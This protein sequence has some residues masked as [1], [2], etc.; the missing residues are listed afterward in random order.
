MSRGVKSLREERGA[1]GGRSRRKE[2]EERGR[3]KRKEQERAAWGKKQERG[4]S[5]IIFEKKDARVLD[6]ARW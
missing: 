5:R 3:N 2:H 1:A 4:T 6:Q